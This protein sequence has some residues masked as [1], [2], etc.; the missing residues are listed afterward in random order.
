M[1]TLI[2]CLMNGPGK[3]LRLSG[4]NKLLSI[5]EDVPWLHYLLA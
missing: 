2:I 3:Q 1:S 5:K 4:V